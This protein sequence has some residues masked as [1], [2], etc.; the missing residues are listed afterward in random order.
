MPRTTASKAAN[1][2][3]GRELRKALGGGAAVVMEDGT[4]VMVRLVPRGGL[5]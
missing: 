4:D 1:A 5:I 2:F 3:A